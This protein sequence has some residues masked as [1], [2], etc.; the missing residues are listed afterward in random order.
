MKHLHPKFV[1]EQAKI[2]RAGLPEA[3]GAL[4][5]FDDLTPIQVLHA[6]FKDSM[7]KSY[8]YCW[9]MYDIEDD[10]VRKYISKY[11]QKQGAVRIQKSVFLW[12]GQKERLA[13]MQKALA[14]VQKMYENEDSILFLEIS[15]EQMEKTRIIGKHIDFEWMALRTT[16]IVL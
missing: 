13:R 15:W 12:K 4:A 7:K 8:Q 6:F 9:I 14:E 1:I 3:F 5:A 2:L 16:T 10:K 11:V